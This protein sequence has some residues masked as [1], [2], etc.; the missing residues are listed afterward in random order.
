MKVLLAHIVYD[1]GIDNWYRQV[2]RTA[3]DQLNV[4]TFNTTLDRGKPKLKWRDLD[5]MWKQ[6]EPALM[7]RYEQLQQAADDCDV[8]LNYNGANIHPEMLQ[9]LPTYNVFCCFDDPESSLSLSEPVAHAFDAAFYGNIAS[10]FQYRSWECRRIAWLPIFYGTDF[11]R[12]DESRVIDQSNR[13]IDI[14]LVCAVNDFRKNRLKM[15]ADS[16]TQAQCYGTG[17]QRGPVSDAQLDRLYRR[18]RIGWNIHNTTGPINQRLFQLTAYGVMQICDNK[19]GLGRIFKIGD[20]IAGFDTIPEAIELTHYYLKH[21]DERREVARNAYRRFWQEYH[22]QAIWNRFAEQVNTWLLQDGF[23]SRHHKSE[24][25]KRSTAA[26]IVLPL[27]WLKQKYIHLR[28]GNCQSELLQRQSG[29][30]EAFYT[31]MVED[32]DTLFDNESHDPVVENVDTLSQDAKQAGSDALAWAAASLAGQADRILEISDRQSTLSDYLV[33]RGHP[34]VRQLNLQYALAGRLT[35]TGDR[36][37][38]ADRNHGHQGTGTCNLILAHNVP[39]DEPG[40]TNLVS[41]C[42]AI[43]TRLIL[44]IPVSCRTRRYRSM[45]SKLYTRPI[46]SAAL[47]RLL[48]QYY[49]NIKLYYLPRCFVPWLEPCMQNISGV[50]FVADCRTPRAETA[51]LAA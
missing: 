26:R 44:T 23:Q 27:N 14:S 37:A 10:E 12:H 7:R 3:G 17:W 33:L 39:A 47:Y 49:E 24:L 19:T 2:A 21:E 51:R 8:L 5:R 11:P 38:D 25:P 36:D 4:V 35:E 16:F 30:D 9:Y 13:D 20:E 48:K 43:D 46:H 28:T 32:Q 18:T 1:D 41:A 42:S 34:A 6:R 15:L 45:R 31:G 29:V 22:P 50:P 40:L